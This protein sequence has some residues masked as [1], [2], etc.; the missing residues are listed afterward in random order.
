MPSMENHLAPSAI[1]ASQRRKPSALADLPRSIQRVA[2]V[3]LLSLAFSGCYF[4]FG[5]YAAFNPA[6][7][8][9]PWIYT[10]YF[11]NFQYMIH[12][13]GATYY[14]C[15]LPWILPGV[16]AYKILPPL[17]AALALKSALAAISVTALYFTIEPRYGWV[18]ALLSSVALI[19]NPYFIYAISWEYPD[20]PAIMY[21]F[22]ALMW[23]LHPEISPWTSA[24]CG[25]MFL[26]LCGYTNLAALPVLIAICVIPL[27]R[28]RNSFRQVAQQAAGMFLGG[29]IVTLVLSIPGKLILNLYLF[30]WPQIEQIQYTRSHPDYLPHMWGTGNAWIPTAFRLAPPLMMLVLGAVWWFRKRRSAEYTA[31]YLFFLLS[32]LLFVVFEFRTS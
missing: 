32:C 19:I 3:F 20:G 1:D 31:V 13:Y 14:L 11:T 8:L 27:W 5:P 22:V 25:G 15:R 6:G 2:L 28:Y 24:L 10:G 9:D 30:F 12:Q 26:A 18:A 29:C 17:A 4:C 7:Y 21:G 16:L 23:L